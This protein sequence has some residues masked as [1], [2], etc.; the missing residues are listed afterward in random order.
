[1]S[2]AYETLIRVQMRTVSGAAEGIVLTAARVETLTQ[3]NVKALPTLKLGR[4]E[5]AI[6]MGDQSDTM[7]LWPDLRGEL[8]RTDVHATDNVASQTVDIPRRYTAVV[9]PSVLLQDAYLT[10]RMEAPAD[11]V[12]IVYGGRLYNYSSGSYIDFLHSFDEGA[13][14]IRSYRMSSVAKPYDVIHYETVTAIPAGVRTVLL[15]FLIHNT[16]ATV[17]HASGLYAARMEANYRP[18]GASPRPIDVFFNGRRS[19]PIGRR[20][21]AATGS[22]SRRFPSSTSSTSAAPIIQSWNRSG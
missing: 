16:S 21:P 5:I 19:A 6:G 9:Y 7:V 22:G 10:Y 17:A 3:V 12:R 18:A 13:T 11:I 1:M 4:N 14:W 8:W 20:S 2:G 15:K